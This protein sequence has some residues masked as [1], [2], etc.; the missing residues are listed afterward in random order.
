MRSRI[1]YAFLLLFAPFLM[2]NEGCDQNQLPKDQG[3]RLKR[4]VELGRVRAP[5]VQFPGAPNF[6]FEFV[7]NSQIY[8]A[9][10]GIFV[11]DY[12]SS[13]P[14]LPG[15]L[16]PQDRLVL[17]P[18]VNY[19]PRHALAVSMAE[20][21]NPN[22]CVVNSPFMMLA[23]DARSFQVTSGGGLWFGYSGQQL[24][25]GN[26]S[27]GANIGIQNA[28][29]EVAMVAY[30]PMSRAIL[31]RS[32]ATAN[33]TKTDINLTINFGMFSIGPRFFYESPLS[34]V[35]M[36]GLSEAARMLAVDIDAEAQKQNRPRWETQVIRDKDLYVFVRAGSLHGLKVGDEFAVYN[37]EH[38]WDGTP[39]KSKYLGSLPT[40]NKPISILRLE[41]Q[42]DVG[43]VFARLRRLE[44][45]SNGEIALA[46]AMV[47]VHKLV[48]EA[49]APPKAQPGPSVP[50]VAAPN[51]A[52]VNPPSSSPAQGPDDGNLYGGA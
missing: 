25:N 32:M 27:G 2:G 20:A 51:P 21:K 11:V 33:H 43:E 15:S 35:T 7:L 37:V 38:F 44:D 8:D 16:A 3:Y 18:P 26:L 50:P 46:G 22:A 42:T 14:N 48:D 52:P 34:K 47:V 1:R 30:N 31:G 6:D 28:Q 10:K 13:D 29:M 17:T 45:T 49:P 41:N 9:V 36:K 23:A 39:C 24:G 40:T 12:N 19:S 5:M 4:Q